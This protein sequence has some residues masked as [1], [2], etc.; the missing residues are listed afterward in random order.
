MFCQP[1]F[2]SANPSK[3]HWHLLSSVCEIQ[4]QRK[5][6]YVA[7]CFFTLRFYFAKIANAHLEQDSR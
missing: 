4:G 3:L 7:M 2:E 5:P 6:I 1:W